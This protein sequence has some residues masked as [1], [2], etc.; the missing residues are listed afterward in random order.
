MDITNLLIDKTS[1]QRIA[2]F[3]MFKNK[4]EAV[5]NSKEI[6]AKMLTSP[7]LPEGDDNPFFKK[8]LGNRDLPTSLRD[9]LSEL[10]KSEIIVEVKINNKEKGYKL[11]RTSEL[12]LNAFAVNKRRDDFD[13]LEQLKHDFDKY[14][15]PFNDSVAR[16]LE[17][18]RAII[19]NNEGINEKDTII[20]F[21]TP[22]IM[23]PI[24][25]QILD[26]FYYAIIERNPIKKLKYKGSYNAKLQP[27]TNTIKEFHPYLIKESKGQWYI[28]GKTPNDDKF[29]HIAI[30]RIFN[31]SFEIDED[32]QFY[33]QHF[34]PANYWKGCVG[35]TKLGNAINLHFK[36][37][38]GEV[39][40]NIDYLLDTPI[41][42]GHQ[43]IERINSVWC[44]V[45]LNDIY[46]GP[47][48]IRV[49]R[50]LG[51]NNIKDM[52]PKWLLEDLWEDGH[53]S[54]FNFSVK[55]PKN[56]T[57][58]DFMGLSKDLLRINKDNDNEVAEIIAKESF[59]KK[60]AGWL[61][62]ELKNILINSVLCYYIE[63]IKNILGEENYY[64]KSINV[65]N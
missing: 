57:I 34:N 19:Q 41:I 60:N 11:N 61:N 65:I 58:N 38:N 6:L 45:K 43:T 10:L 5:F 18:S 55:L 7:D 46:A 36:L 28:I 13:V 39:Y 47:E 4:P 23:N 42:K 16:I 15:L 20:D 22:L 63:E 32:T 49:L 54:N 52:K 30:N 26:A 14:N 1:L 40:N 25:E 53:R 21:E 9:R 37:K 44:D 35:I 12:D 64:T 50:S 8:N 51:R 48:L 33:R 17:E 3:N 29:K 2:L 31:N 27:I 24:F 59:N 56:I 62:I